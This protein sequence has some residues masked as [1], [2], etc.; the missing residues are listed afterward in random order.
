[1]G[2]RTRLAAL[3]A[4]LALVA[5]CA[6]ERP[7]G[8]G[9]AATSLRSGP[10]GAAA[11]E[12]PVAT[13]AAYVARAASYNLLVIRASELL[14]APAANLAHN[15]AALD[16]ARD[17]RGLAAQLSF[18]GR[19]LDLLPGAGLLPNHQRWLDEFAAAP[20]EAAYLRL[21]RRVHQN[22]H[23]LHAAFAARGTSPTLR[24]VAANAAAV[25]R[26]HWGLLQ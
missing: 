7:V 26:R 21:M 10:R 5:G 17:H 15:L 1:M 14:P 11:E 9:A 16:L 19:R 24:A 22:S 8:P 20:T 23:A 13:P 6:A 25:E 4:G 2:G 18:A 3:G 12:A